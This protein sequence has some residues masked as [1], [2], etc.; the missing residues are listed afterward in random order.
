MIQPSERNA[1]A[2]VAALWLAVVGAVGIFT[3][4][5]GCGTLKPPPPADCVKAC[6][7]VAKLGC[8]TAPAT[9]DALC[10]SVYPTNPGYA[11]CVAAAGSCD[12][13]NACQ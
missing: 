3:A 4:A 9:C 7:N 6:G 1:V 5:H 11:A 12:D 10:S 8:G 2:A 13:A